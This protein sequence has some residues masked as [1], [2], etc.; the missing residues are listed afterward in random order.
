MGKREHPIIQDFKNTTTKG[1]RSPNDTVDFLRRFPINILGGDESLIAPL[2]KDMYRRLERGSETVHSMSPHDL[3]YGPGL[4]LF[5]L[6]ILR[7][8][9]GRTSADDDEIYRLLTTATYEVEAE[10]K[11]REEA[12]ATTRIKTGN[13]ATDSGEEEK[14]DDEESTEP[15]PTYRIIR[16][17]T[18]PEQALAARLG[19]HNTEGYADDETS[20]APLHPAPFMISINQSFDLPKGEPSAFIKAREDAPP[21]MWPRSKSIGLSGGLL[22]DPTLEIHIP[23]SI[24]PPKPR[25]TAMMKRVACKRSFARW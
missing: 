4:Q 8:Y 21:Y 3:V 20:I 7:L 23:K 19:W 24:K 1:I 5:K 9:F 6:V 17:F 16:R 22:Y 12:Q 11:R 13:E 2:L 14:S 15:Q 25:A 18:T 10:K